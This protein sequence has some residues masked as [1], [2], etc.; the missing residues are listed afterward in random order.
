[1]IRGA[2]IIAVCFAIS[3]CSPAA[4]MR[5]PDPTDLSKFNIGDKRTDVTAQI[6]LPITTN[7][8]DGNLCDM[9]QLYISGPSTAGKAGIALLEGVA[10]VATLGLAEALLTPVEVATH[11]TKYTVIMCYGKDD[12]IVSIRKSDAPVSQ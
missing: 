1:M 5:R 6:G 7:P 2:I 3:G 8:D 4:E 9:Y 12:R 10:D 11:S